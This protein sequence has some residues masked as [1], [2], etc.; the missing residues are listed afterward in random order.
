MH[1]CKRH[2]SGYH[3]IHRDTER[4][5]IASFIAVSASLLLWGYVVYTAHCARC[6]RIAA[7]CLGDTEI[8]D[9]D[10]SIFRYNNILWLDVTV[11]NMVLMRCFQTGCDLDGEVDGC[12]HIETTVLLDILL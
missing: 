11:N 5:N 6:K 12:L 1:E 4:I 9:L 3:L 2:S 8:C 7:R 10:I